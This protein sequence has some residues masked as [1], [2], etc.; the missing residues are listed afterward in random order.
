MSSNISNETIAIHL[1]DIG[2]RQLFTRTGYYKAN[3]VAIKKIN[4]SRID[5]TKPLLLE[6]KRVRNIRVMNV[7]TPSFSQQPKAAI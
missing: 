7:L 4:R 2:N 6:F 1:S 5:I 3:L